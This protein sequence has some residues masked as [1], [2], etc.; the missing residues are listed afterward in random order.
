MWPVRLVGV[1]TVAL[2]ATIWPAVPA[3]AA[4]ND[5]TLISRAS[6]PTGPAANDHADRASVSAD[7]RFVVFVS[8]ADN[9]S[10]EDNDGV[11]NVFVRDRQAGT[12][13]FVSR[14]NGATGVGADADSTGPTISADGR[15][16][17]FASTAGNL[18]NED[19]DSCPQLWG[20]TMPCSDVFVRDLQSGTTTLVSRADGMT[21]A[22]AAGDSFVPAIFPDGGRVV[23][24]SV[25]ANLSAEDTDECTNASETGP[26]SAPC[27]N[28]FVR[29][30]N[31]GTT[32][33][34]APGRHR[35]W[36][37][38]CRSA[39]SGSGRYVAIET[40]QALDPA[41]GNEGDDLY[42]IDLQ[43]GAKEWASGPQAGDGHGVD[44]CASL[45]A[46]GRMVA[47]EGWST[48]LD[49]TVPGSS[50]WDEVYVRNLAT[51]VTSVVSRPPNE[52]NARSAHPSIS[53]D[54]R[55]VAFSTEKRVSASGPGVYVRDLQ[56]GGATF[57]GGVGNAGTAGHP[58]I[59]A[60]GR[61]VAFS[62]D[63][64]S[65][66]SEDS[67]QY[68]NVFV[69]ELGPA[70]PAPTCTSATVS[71]DADSWVGQDAP[72]ATHG[73]DPA[74]VVRS[75]A[76]AN[77]RALVHFA[78]PAVPAGCRV[79]D[80]KLRLNASAAAAGRTLQ[81]VQLAASW[82]EGG[83]R[84][85]DQPATTGPVATTSSGSGWREWTVTAQVDGMYSGANHGFL[86]RDAGE[87][88]GPTRDQSFRSR[89]GGGSTAPQLVVTFGPAG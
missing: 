26:F 73:A 86:V 87:G 28:V 50:V 56:T 2:V 88:S 77:R 41:D 27:F 12:T 63:V 55:Y 80:A 1:V 18:S 25:A 61:F 39:V 51:G 9:L 53:G 62:S 54:G 24:V 20:G 38:G 34:L 14:A 16:V 58:S 5:L 43:T 68:R 30:L 37:E 85:N 35:I 45:S 3:K 21:G 33:Y 15:Y 46:D 65:I 6:G 75:K 36:A 89:E 44:F 22:S 69:R 59:S 32:R 47:F 66:S 8:G 7:G 84:W 83:V 82:T 78:L 81:A 23:F 40:D 72:A 17:A 48:Q 49:G 79:T 13:T 42:V 29:D 11:A 70:A 60:D 76:Q 71:A 10:V 19:G 64:D 31:A 4:P 52:W 74:L 57:V 67:D